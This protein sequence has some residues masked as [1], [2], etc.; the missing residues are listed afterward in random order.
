VY[1]VGSGPA[2]LPPDVWIE[3]VIHSTEVAGYVET[4]VTVLAGVR[5]MARKP[6]TVSVQEGD[7]VVGAKQVIPDNDL[8]VLSVQFDVRPRG[9]GVTLYTAAAK[10]DKTEIYDWNNDEDFFMNVVAKQRRVLYVEGAPRYEYRFLRAA[11]ENDERFQVTSAVFVT[12]DGDTY[13]Q[14]IANSAELRSGFPLTEEEL[15]AYDVVVIGNVRATRFTTNQLE[16]LREFVRR[17]GGGL[18]FL[19]G[20]DSFRRGGFGISPLADALPFEMDRG[21][22]GLV[23][24]ELRVA[25][26][27]L[28]IERNL[29]GA[30]TPNDRTPPPWEELPAL[31]GLYRLDGLKPGAQALCAIDEGRGTANSPVVAFQRY[32]KG[33]CLVNGVSATWPWKFQMPSDDARYQSFWKEMVLVLMESQ[34]GMLRLN[35]SP[36][37][38]T[39]RATLSISGAV[40]NTAFE[41]DHNAPVDLE[42]ERPDGTRTRIAPL[43][44][45]EPNT[46]FQRDYVPEEPGVYRVRATAQGAQT[47]ET[48]AMFIVK[49][50]SPELAAVDLN[51]PLLKEIAEAPGGAYVHLS[52]Y[53]SL[54][55]R[56]KPGESAIY[57]ETQR[58]LW[59][60]PWVMGSILALLLGEWL[61]R[62]IGGLA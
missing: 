35:V 27:R 26:T 48:E 14:G 4:P 56:I 51:T 62:R 47:M 12:R 22:T 54:L 8:Q 55:D 29:F 25:P 9:E 33:V 36:A 38:T 53:G 57:H 3:K 18:L 13:R 10:A 30:Y 50:A 41:L 6:V 20:D 28:G 40:L 49:D 23:D 60:S 24:R 7:R 42:L 34:Q 39:P 61:I 17:R 32:G 52:D 31:N 58:A 19:A 44:S 15:F 37:V 5:G 46:T 11:F 2:E 43:R 21:L 45:T 16:M 1:A 59:D